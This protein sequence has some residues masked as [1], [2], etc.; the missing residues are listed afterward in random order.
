MKIWGAA[1]FQKSLVFEILRRYKKN[2]IRRFLK[3]SLLLGQPFLWRHARDSL[4]L[5]IE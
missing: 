3:S 2:A 5:A 4:E 1:K